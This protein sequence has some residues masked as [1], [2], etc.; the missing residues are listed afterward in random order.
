MA[1]ESSFTSSLCCY[2]LQF[3]NEIPLTCSKLQVVF[4]LLLN[5]YYEVYRTSQWKWRKQQWYLLQ[6]TYIVKLKHVFNYAKLQLVFF[7]LF[8]LLL[9][10]EVHLFAPAHSQSMLPVKRGTP[11]LWVPGK[12]A[13]ETHMWKAWLSFNWNLFYA[14]QR[15]HT[16]TAIWN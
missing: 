11:L 1:C 7:L 2:Y 6:K 12:R 3:V 13:F 15:L 14:S 8:L 16:T 4:V 10:A 5:F 9:C